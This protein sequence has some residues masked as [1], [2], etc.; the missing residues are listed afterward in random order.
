MDELWEKFMQ[1]GLVSD[2]I[3]YI[4]FGR[5]GEKDADDFKRAGASREKRR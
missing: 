1:T 4:G 2:Y 5:S 3:K